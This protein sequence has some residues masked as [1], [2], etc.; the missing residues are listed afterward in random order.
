MVSNRETIEKLARGY[1]PGAR[2]DESRTRKL[3]IEMKIPPFE[4][5]SPLSCDAVERLLRER[6]GGDVPLVMLPSTHPSRPLRGRVRG[7]RFDVR[8]K[9]PYG[10]SFAAV[11]RGIIEP[12]PGGSRIHADAGMPGVTMLFMAFWGLAAVT[13]VVQALVAR[14]SADLRE[15]VGMLAA[16]LAIVGVGRWL[17][18]NEAARIR[19]HLHQALTAAARTSPRGT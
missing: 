19:E 14:D 18:R 17:A 3:Q 2:H 13:F 16:G 1:H 6:V 9:T 10:N 7:G 4:L 15:A 5:E 11:Y 12:R 8:L